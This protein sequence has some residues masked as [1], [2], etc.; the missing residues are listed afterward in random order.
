MII[1]SASFICFHVFRSSVLSSSAFPFVAI[2]LC[3]LC[4]LLLSFG[5][6][7]SSSVFFFV[8]YYFSFF[9][10]PLLCLVVS[11]CVV[12]VFCFVFCLIVFFSLLLSLLLSVF[13]LLSSA[14]SFLFCLL[15]SLSIF[16]CIRLNN[17]ALVFCLHKKRM[18]VHSPPLISFILWFIAL[19]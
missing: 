8:F 4:L 11:I 19:V 17:S 5:L 14:L 1:A 15:L 12:P 13:C 10:F 16:F 6:V 9:G 7:V 18:A 3:A 2:R